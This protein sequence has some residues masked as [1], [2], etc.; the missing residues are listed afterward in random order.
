MESFIYKQVTLLISLVSLDVNMQLLEQFKVY[1]QIETWVND[2]EWV[3]SKL[4]GRE[5]SSI[6]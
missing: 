2:G 3:P 5:K 1:H 4:D 6:R